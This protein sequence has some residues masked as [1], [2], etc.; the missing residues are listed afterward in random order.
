MSKRKF[1]PLQPPPRWLNCPR[2]ANSLIADKFVAF[3]VPLSTKFNHNVPI[4]N[5]FHM[6]LL[7]DS[8]KKSFNVKNKT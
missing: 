1:D 7:I 2:K 3:K 6:S 4:E 5:R 8:V